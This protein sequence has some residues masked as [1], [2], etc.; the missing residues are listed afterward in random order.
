MFQKGCDFFRG[1]FSGRCWHFKCVYLF[2]SFI[3][4]RA[5]SLQAI[6]QMYRSIYCSIFPINTILSDQFASTRGWLKLRYMRA[7]VYKADL[8]AMVYFNIDRHRKLPMPVVN[9]LNRFQNLNCV[10]T[11]MD[12]PGGAS[13]KESTCQCRGHKRQGFDPWVGKIPWRRA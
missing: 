9:W 12:F 7:V 10:T 6:G 5:S 1:H 4:S 3:A 13:G 8:N 2:I 11:F